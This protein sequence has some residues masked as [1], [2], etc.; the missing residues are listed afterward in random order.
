M[1]VTSVRRALLAALLLVCVCAPSSASAS[2][3]HDATEASIIRAINKASA[4]ATACPALR[5][6]RGLARA[7]DAHSRDDAPHEH[8]RSRRRSPARPA[9]RAHAQASGENLA[10]MEGCNAHEIVQMWL[11][12]RAAPRDHALAVLPAHRRRPPRLA[13]V[14]RDR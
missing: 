10:W 5:T 3:R 4:R 7:A 13:A 9:L 1:S 6:N 2:S 14:L 12:S 11:N 8:A